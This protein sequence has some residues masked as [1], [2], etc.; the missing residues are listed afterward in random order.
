[1]TKWKA[2]FTL[3]IATLFA[4]S[5][6]F[7]ASAVIPALRQSW[8]LSGSAAS[9]LT[10]AV[11]LGFVIGTLLSAT[12][13]LPD[14][15]NPRY[16]FAICAIGA[17]FC[18]ALL[19]SSFSGPGSAIA[20]RFAT[21]MFLAGVY[22]PAMKIMASWF[23]TGRGT[24]IGFLIGALTLG[25]AFPY[26]INVFGLNHWKQNLLV[27]S[28]FAILGAILI[29]FFLQDGPFRQPSA[30]FDITQIRKAF[31][32]RGVRLANFGYFGHMWELYAMWAWV[33]VM[34][35]A[36]FVLSDTPSKW[37]EA[38]SFGTIGAGVVGCVVAGILADR[39]GRTIIASAAMIL[40]GTCCIVIGFLFGG[41]PWMLTAITLIWGATVVA[42]S[43]Q[44]STCVTELADPRYIG[45]ALTI[46]TC[47]GFLLTMIT[48]EFIPH[49]VDL[50]GWRYAFIALAP[51]PFLGVLFMLRLRQ[52]PEAVRIAHGKR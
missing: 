24:A 35:R 33:P 4:M 20:L 15:M 26:L 39:M 37:A 34:I 22:P 36:S 21:G 11:Q 9:W 23:Q 6:W 8:N 17:A 28:G 50:V 38:V 41:N 12:L 10:L 49:L 51:G 45:T 40:S 46:Q 42:D 14:I 32:N 43:A 3:G 25:K 16:L 19:A 2:M 47:I 13:N 44:F 18:T 7:S 29:R 48:I 52:L 30:P 31:A 5:V 27:V 1:M